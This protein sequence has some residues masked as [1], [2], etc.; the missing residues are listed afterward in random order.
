MKV[1]LILLQATYVREHLLM[2]VMTARR[3][4]DSHFTIKT[5]F[6]IALKNNKSAPTT[7]RR[8]FAI[9]NFSAAMWLGVVL[10]QSA[11][12]HHGALYPHQAANIRTWQVWVTS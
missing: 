3:A 4:K 11:A 7:R 1:S 10:I 8:N 12:C 9:Y 6:F 5:L 2:M